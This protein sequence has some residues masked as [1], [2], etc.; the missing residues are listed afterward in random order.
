MYIRI[1]V[2]Q[3]AIYSPILYGTEI[4]GGSIDPFDTAQPETDQSLVAL[5]M[6]LGGAS[7]Q[8]HGANAGGIPNFALMS[9][10]R[11]LPIS[12]YAAARRVRLFV[13]APR[14]RTH[15][16]LSFKLVP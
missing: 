8:S 5:Y 10:M 1:M 13:K 14:L 2:I 15:L 3:M 6:V 9:E 7:L 12:V 11:L 16:A 4:T